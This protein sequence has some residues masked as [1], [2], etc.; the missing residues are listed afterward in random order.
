MS[1]FTSHLGLQMVED[2]QGRPVLRAGRC[3]WDT[4]GDLSYDVGEEGSGQ[5]IYVES[6]SRTDLAS[7]PRLAWTILP[8]DGP[9]LKAAVLHDRLYERRGDVTRLGHPALYTRAEA[10]AILNE[11]M[12]VL[13]VPDE[14]RAMIYRAVR[15]GGARAFGT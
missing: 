4:V 3:L 7:I 8:P 15:L 2:A 10:D 14:Q 12:G 5:T 6:G 1:R 11:A 13:G 9:W